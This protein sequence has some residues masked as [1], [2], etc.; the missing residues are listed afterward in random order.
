MTISVTI[1]S[2]QRGKKSRGREREGRRQIP[3]PRADPPEPSSSPLSYPT[4]RSIIRPNA[5]AARQEQT[6]LGKLWKILRPPKFLPR[7]SSVDTRTS[8]SRRRPSCQR[9]PT[10]RRLLPAC[11][12]ATFFAIFSTRLSSR[13]RGHRGKKMGVFSSSSGVKVL[14]STKEV[15]VAVSKVR[16]DEF[17]S[18]CVDL[19]RFAPPSGRL[20]SSISI[21]PG[22]ALTYTL[23]LSYSRRRGIICP[24]MNPRRNTCWL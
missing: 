22:L 19:R 6:P 2:R 16:V 24:M 13:P 4:C 1:D 9:R 3:R 14:G 20:R 7:R 11:L 5:H 10:Y 23:I 17:A 15:D 18:I 12:L 21:S 8:P